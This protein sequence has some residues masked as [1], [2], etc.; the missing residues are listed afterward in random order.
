MNSTTQ[1]LIFHGSVVLV[2][3]FLLGAPYGRAINRGASTRS[4]EA[5]RLAHSSLI[6]GAILMLVV[7]LV[8]PLLA[9][10]EPLRWFITLALIVSSYSF[11][12][13]LTLGPLLGHRGLSSKDS[14][15]AKLVYVGNMIGAGGALLAGLGLLYASLVT[16][17]SGP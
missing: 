13:S 8:L 11:C 9:V 10:A 6:M 15:S 3:A 5:W 14:G 4:V 12:V 17:V 1:H 2:Y 16:L 7:A